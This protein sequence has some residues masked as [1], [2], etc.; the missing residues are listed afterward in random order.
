M[1]LPLQMEPLKDYRSLFSSSGPGQSSQRESRSHQK[2]SKL[3]TEGQKEIF[4]VLLKS[5][6]PM[7]GQV[8]ALCAMGEVI[9]LTTLCL[10]L[11]LDTI[12]DIVIHLGRDCV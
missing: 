4:T 3:Q 5:S 2:D 1:H 11:D 9:L 7:W 8:K 6:L 12:I 10:C